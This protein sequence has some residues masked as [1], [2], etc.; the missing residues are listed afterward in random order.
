[1]LKFTVNIYLI[2][3][4]KIKK[5]INIYEIKKCVFFFII[6]KITNI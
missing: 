4:K 2:F 6:K 5:K 3:N 1:M